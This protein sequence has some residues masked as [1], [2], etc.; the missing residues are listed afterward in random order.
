M[1]RLEGCPHVTES[2]KTKKPHIDTFPM[3]RC[4]AEDIIRVRKA[5]ISGR[6]RKRIPF[7]ECGAGKVVEVA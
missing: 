3:R 5:V 4:D 2:Y 7:R 6:S 1:V